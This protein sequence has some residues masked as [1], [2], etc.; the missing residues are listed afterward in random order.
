[1]IAVDTSALMAIV[2]KDPEADACKTALTAENEVLISAGTLAEAL[3]C[4]GPA[5]RRRPDGEDRRRPRL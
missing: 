3:N 4:L 5:R 2:L 1:M